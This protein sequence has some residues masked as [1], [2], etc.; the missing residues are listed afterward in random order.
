MKNKKINTGQSWPSVWFASPQLFYDWLIHFSLAID[1]WTR[2]QFLFVG[3]FIIQDFCVICSSLQCRQKEDI[4]VTIIKFYDGF[5]GETDTLQMA[6]IYTNVDTLINKRSYTVSYFD[7]FHID[8][9]ETHQIA[10]WSCHRAIQ[11][12]IVQQTN[13][14]CFK[15]YP[16]CFNLN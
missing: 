15:L 12:K 14:P 4:A 16:H 2:M 8:S 10:I 11:N 13:S 3:K 1:S 5:S 6:N 9:S 7:T